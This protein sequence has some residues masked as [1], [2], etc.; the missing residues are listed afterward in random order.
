MIILILGGSFYP[1]HSGHIDLLYT[2]K[3]YFENKGETV[4]ELLICPSHYR[5]LSQKFPK[6]NQTN[7]NRIE[8][9]NEFLKSYPDV[10]LDATII[11]SIKNMG[12][13]VHM[14][15]LRI[16][17][18]TKG[19]RLIQVCG[20]DSK[21]NFTKS[22]SNV[23]IIEDGR[24]IPESNKLIIKQATNITKSNFLV[25]KTSSTIERFINQ[26]LY[27][28]STICSFSLDWL[29]D[30]GIILG[31][32][33]QGTVKLMYLG[34]LEVAVKLQPINSKN[35]SE[36][37]LNSC[38]LMEKINKVYSYGIEELIGWIVYDVHTPLNNIIPV[39][40]S[41]NNK[42]SVTQMAKFL[43][44][45]EKFMCLHVKKY[46]TVDYINTTAY[47]NNQE[48][49]IKYN[50]NPILFK[51]IVAEE[52]DVILEKLEH[53]K[54]IHRDIYYDNVLLT[55]NLKVIIIDFGV[56]KKINS[57]LHILRGSLRYYSPMAILNANNYDY[58]CDKYM[59]SFI[60]YE[61][62]E[63]HE[64]YP[65]YIGDTENIIKSRLNNLFPK[66]S[67]KSKNFEQLVTKIN[68]LWKLHENKEILLS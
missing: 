35:T 63:E 33:A 26:D 42:R 22:N 48:L 2:A 29:T 7:D 57:S 28:K 16:E 67:M 25:P 12:F 20:T 41:Y 55:T 62:I 43:A 9:I 47:K 18:E 37:F 40:H 1:I 66:W 24:E 15:K 13:S 32:G 10:R 39:K 61:M 17:C 53:C 3:K 65:E 31:T 46:L 6:I 14:S 59:A 27:H 19:N 64:I 34:K 30:S 36:Q 11:S 4:L 45:I 21:I 23:L 5:S 49:I 44:E 8:F 58:S 56:S 68:E 51:Q 54:I 52:F 50:S 38:V 60:I